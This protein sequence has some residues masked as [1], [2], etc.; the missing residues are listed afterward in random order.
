MKMDESEG[1]GKGGGGRGAARPRTGGAPKL[2]YSVPE[3]AELLGGIELEAEAAGNG[4]VRVSCPTFRPDLERPVDLVEELGRLKGFDQIPDTLPAGRLRPE[5]R[6]AVEVQGR[7][8]GEFLAD[9]GCFEVINLSFI[10]PRRLDEM[11]LAPDHPWRRTVRDRKS[12]V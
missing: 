10:N 8:A 12:G 7:R 5:P 3:A 6:D 2:C 1:S 11:G 9:L 4:L